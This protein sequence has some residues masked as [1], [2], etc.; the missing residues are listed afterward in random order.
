V[1]NSSRGPRKMSHYNEDGLRIRKEKP[2][3]NRVREKH[4]KNALRSP[5]LVDFLSEEDEEL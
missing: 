5:H 1:S 3:M 4:I 2:H